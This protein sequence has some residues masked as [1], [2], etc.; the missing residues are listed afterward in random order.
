MLRAVLCV[1]FFGTN[2]LRECPVDYFTLAVTHKKTPHRNSTC[3][4][5]FYAFG[6]GGGFRTF[7]WLKKIH[8]AVCMYG[9]C[10]D[11]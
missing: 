9:F 11:V 3:E 6:G 7:M 5:F 8:V 4:A 2:L 1:A 10:V